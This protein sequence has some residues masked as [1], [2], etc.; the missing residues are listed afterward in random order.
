MSCIV[1]RT[2]GLIDLRAFTIMG[3]SSKP[4]VAN[5]IGYFGTGLKYAMA[6]LVRLGCEP[7]V[8]IGRDRHVF[9]K[10]QD[11]FRGKDFETIS[12]RSM[13]W[14]LSRWRTTKL[15]FTTQYGRNWEP[16]MA[17]REL[18]ANTRDEG[19]TTT[20]LESSSSI[21]QGVDG[22]T[23]IV[24]DLPA[25]VD[26]YRERDNIFLPGAGR[27]GSATVE[28]LDGPSE[29]LY[30]RGMRVYK[31]G[32]PSR[33]TY[34]LISH[35]DLTEDRTLQH[36]YYA[37]STI[38]QFVV[39]SNSDHVVE[40][41]LTA[42]SKFWEHGMEFNQY[43]APGAAFKRVMERLPRRVFG[44]AWNY[45]ARYDARVTA[46]TYDL[47]DHHPPP[48]EHSGDA[49]L[50]AKGTIVFDKPVGYVGKWHL[51]ADALLRRVNRSLP[52]EAQEQEERQPGEGG[53]L[54]STE[55]LGD[56]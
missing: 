28:V 33:L 50:D 19:G 47:D 34:N 38:A 36:E 14:G 17:F 2:P 7:E 26:A 21:V 6:V 41:V 22:D 37:R 3:M 5:P 25:F 52:D 40:N 12:I 30:W 49:V 10:S 24:I 15:P 42:G 32:K 44:N 4:N 20:H 23:K 46:D 55:A 18:E 11:S 35:M 51:M 31:L 56:G 45:Y 29:H 39:S 8:W 48:W 13:R 43:T 9:V 54:E 53:A 27:D 16:W 1:F